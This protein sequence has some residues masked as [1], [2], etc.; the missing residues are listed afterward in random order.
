[1]HN[2]FVAIN[3]NSKGIF[4]SG[5]FASLFLNGSLSA[6]KALELRIFFVFCNISSSSSP[7]SSMRPIVAEEEFEVTVKR[8][9][10]RKL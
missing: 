7:L 2:D 8:S 5:N 6:A 3:F 9:E 10:D 1:M 4:Q